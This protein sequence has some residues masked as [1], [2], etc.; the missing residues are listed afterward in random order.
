[1]SEI[2]FDENK[3]GAGTIGA[4]LGIDEETGEIRCDV[5]CPLCDKGFR[6]IVRP[7]VRCLA[8]KEIFA[9]TII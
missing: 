5:I 4:N 2:K 9:V 7:Y 3:I 1:M 6:V 8:C